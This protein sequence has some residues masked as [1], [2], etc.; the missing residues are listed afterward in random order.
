MARPPSSRHRLV[1]ILLA[2]VA[3]F[4]SAASGAAGEPGK[5]SRQ[6]E[7]FE[8]KIRPV[9]VERCYRCHS[10]E[11]KKQEARLRL[12]NRESLR[13]GGESGPAIVPGDPAGSL[14]MQALRY[15]GL[16]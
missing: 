1:S 7:F 5:D 12:D 16:V 2:G 13:R 11:S 8:Q 14:L 3:V 15:E 6:A 4:S 9:L 10:A